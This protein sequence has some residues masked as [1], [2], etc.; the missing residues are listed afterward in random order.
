[1]TASF[2]AFVNEEVEEEVKMI[3]RHKI[4]LMHL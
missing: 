4:A 3:V 1:M 2:S